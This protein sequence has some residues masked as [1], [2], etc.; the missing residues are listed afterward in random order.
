MISRLLLESVL[1]ILLP[2]QEM[3]IFQQKPLSLS[4][5]IPSEYEKKII[6]K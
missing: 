6:K 3:H 5:L 2:L 1:I 4:Q